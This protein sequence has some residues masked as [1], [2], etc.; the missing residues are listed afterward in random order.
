MNI[1][2]KAAVITVGAFAGAALAANVLAVIL[3]N[4]TAEQIASI[5]S[6]GCMA[7]LAFFF[8]KLILINL[9]CKEMAKERDEAMKTVD[10]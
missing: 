1:K 4:L 6:W 10:R 8:Y 3:A 5:F 2:L 7:V 9:E